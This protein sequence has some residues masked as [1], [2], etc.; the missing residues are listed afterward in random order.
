M[1]RNIKRQDCFCVNL[2]RQA[3]FFKFKLGLKGLIGID[4]SNI[5]NEIS[6]SDF[7][8]CSLYILQRQ[9]TRRLDVSTY[10]INFKGV[11]L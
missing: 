8:I 7:S 10:Y 11:C 1:C 6:L 3:G 5:F 2:A 9:L 4:F